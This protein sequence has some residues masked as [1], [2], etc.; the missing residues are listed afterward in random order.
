MLLQINRDSFCVMFRNYYSKWQTKK[1]I[2]EL[3]HEVIVQ[4]KTK[5]LLCIF[6]VG[7]K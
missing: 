7:L 5:K 1:Y 6:F 4:N 3:G 2:E